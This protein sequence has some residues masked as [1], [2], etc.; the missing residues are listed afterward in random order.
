MTLLVD[1]RGV[2]EGAGGED[3]EGE[4]GERGAHQA[5]Q[6]PGQEEAK[7]QEENQGSPR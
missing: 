6:G 7:C 3:Q 5:G 4:D 2:P 1:K